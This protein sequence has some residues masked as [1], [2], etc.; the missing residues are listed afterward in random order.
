MTQPESTAEIVKPSRSVGD[1]VRDCMARYVDALGGDDQ[2]TDEQRAACKRAAELVTLATALRYKAL[3][4][5]EVDVSEFVRVEDLAADAVSR[6]MLPKAK[7]SG[8]TSLDVVFVNSFDLKMQRWIEGRPD[9]QANELIAKLSERITELEK[10]LDDAHAGLRN[11]DIEIKRLKVISRPALEN[12]TT[13]NPRREQRDDEEE[14][15]RRLR[16]LPSPRD[17]GQW[18]ALAAAMGNG[19]VDPVPPGFGPKDRL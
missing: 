4:G 3:G 6:L 10:S 11:A 14:L 13:V 15:S 5:R 16:G 2:V 18:G 19:S 12:V 1:E 9:L 7:T 17:D 8:P